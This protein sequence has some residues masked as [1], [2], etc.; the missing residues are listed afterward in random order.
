MAE[1]YLLKVVE[2]LKIQ[3]VQQKSCK[4]EANELE[5]LVLIITLL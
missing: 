4:A 2:H 3:M 5:D 1:Q